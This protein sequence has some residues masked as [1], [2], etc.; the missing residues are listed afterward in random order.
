MTPLLHLQ[1][2]SKRYNRAPVLEDVNFCVKDGEF[3]VLIGSSGSGKT[4]LLR[5]IAGLEHAESGMV[6][7]RGKVVDAPAKS[8]FVPPERR[9]LGMVFQDY[10]LWPHFTCLQNVE[11]AVPPGTQ[12]RRRVALGMLEQVGIAALAGQQPHRLSGGEQQRVGIARALV[13]RPDFLLLDEPFSSLDVD[14]RERLRMDVRTLAREHGIAALLVTHDPVDAWRLADRI[15]L[16]ESGH[17]TQSATPAQL[18]AR[19]STARAARFV[20]AEGGFVARIQCRC[21]RL[22]IEVLGGFHPVTAIDV[23]EN[24]LGQVFV[25]PDGIHVRAEGLPASL[26]HCSFEAGHYRAYWRVPGW[27]RPLCSIETTLPCSSDV[28]LQIDPEH[29]FV[30]P[31]NNPDQ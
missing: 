14:I 27:D 3:A 11:A 4:T 5:I 24:E 13:A 19:P 28:R 15:V 17:L 20:G 8:V 23:G 30:Y 31:I 25:R 9:G 2:I 1:G 10:A 29:I 16:L 18:Y 7:L 12:D 22:G 6:S 21:Q 26:L